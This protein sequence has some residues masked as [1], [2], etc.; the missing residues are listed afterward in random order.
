MSWQVELIYKQLNN[1]SIKDQPRRTDKKDKR[2]NKCFKGERV[3]AK[4]ER[5]TDV[6]S[7][8]NRCRV[9]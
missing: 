4:G 3:E 2:V 8:T 6:E 9:R 5:K 7:S 1:R